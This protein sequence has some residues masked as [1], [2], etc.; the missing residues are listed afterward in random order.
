RDGQPSSS[1]EP[2][3]E[4]K[5]RR[6]DDAPMP[7]GAPAFFGKRRAKGGRRR[8]AGQHDWPAWGFGRTTARPARARAA[9]FSWA[10]SALVRPAAGRSLATAAEEIA[11]KHNEQERKSSDAP[12]C[13]EL[14]LATTS[15]AWRR[16]VRVSRRS[17]LLRSVG[18]SP[19]AR[20][21][22]RCRRPKASWRP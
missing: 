17:S 20:P 12:G 19:L 8:R 22:G 5:K 9:G 21:A 18:I 15:A 6:G 16:R 13:P 4:G 11:T 14:A 10:G 2:A 1:S 3:R 7:M